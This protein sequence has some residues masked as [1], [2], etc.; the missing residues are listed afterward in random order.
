MGS[1]TLAAGISHGSGFVAD[2]V[3]TFLLVT[4]IKAPR[5]GRRAPA[6]WAGLMIG[7]T[8]TCDIIVFG[9][10]TGA[11]MNPARTFGPY[12][13]NALFGGDTKWGDLY[14]YVLAPLVGGTLAAL[15]YDVVAR[16][17][18]A[19]A[20][21]PI[22]ETGGETGGPPGGDQWMTPSG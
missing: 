13:I 15:A 18:G 7:L 19:E 14:L 21:A 6:G 5:R 16:P 10:V 12:L 3:A 22:G 4:A 2:A 8:V 11:S 1:T 17:R 9:S 20:P